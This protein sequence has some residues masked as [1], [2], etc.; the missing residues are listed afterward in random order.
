MIVG[1]MASE[2]SESVRSQI[3]ILSKEG[4]S[5]CQIMAR[6]NV[7]KGAEHGT[8]KHFAETGSVIS[9]TQS[10]RTKVSTPSEVQYFKL[11]SLRDRKVISS[12][13]Q[14]FLNKEHKTP[15]QKFCQ[16]RDSEDV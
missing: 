10:V 2:L 13:I 15:V 6:L 11:S 3:V 5:Q 16:K 7:S 8:L 4:L 12:Q 14:N 1:N 9:K